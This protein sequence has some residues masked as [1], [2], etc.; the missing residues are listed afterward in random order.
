[1]R[2]GFFIVGIIVWEM[3]PLNKYFIVP[4]IFGYNWCLDQIYKTEGE[5]CMSLLKS[6]VINARPA[7][8]ERGRMGLVH[9]FSDNYKKCA[10]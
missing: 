1:M 3:A 4:E 5:I 7:G 2:E 6:V 8:G 10:L 9:R